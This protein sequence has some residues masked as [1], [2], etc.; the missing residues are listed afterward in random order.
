MSHGQGKP[1]NGQGNVREKSGNFVRAHGWTP[2]N[3]FDL[4]H[5]LE[6]IFEFWRSYVNLAIWWPRSGVR[7]YQIMTGVTS[8]VGVPSTHL[9]QLYWERQ[10]DHHIGDHNLEFI[11]L[12]ANIFILLKILLKFVLRGTINNKPAISEISEPAMCIAQPWWVYGLI[13]W[14][15]D[16]MTHLLQTTISVAFS[17]VKTCEY[18]FKLYGICPYG[19]NWWYSSIGSDNGLVLV[20]QQAII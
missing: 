19:S 7:I 11:F 12:C 6:S 20:R 2:C 10:N 3:G 16:K 8:D 17:S 5:D 14:T 13:H 18:G 15:Q 9:V 4:G 1:Q